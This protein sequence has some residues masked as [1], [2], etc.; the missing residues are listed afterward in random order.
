M[1]KMRL[2][3]FLILLLTECFPF[4]GY[5]EKQDSAQ[6]A[7]KVAG[8]LDIY[9]GQDF[10]FEERKRPYTTQAFYDDEPAINLAFVDTTLTTENYRG[11]IS[12]QAGSSVESNYAAEAAEGWRYVQEAYGGVKLGKGLWLDAGVFFSHIGMEGWI[13]RDNINYTRSLVA[14]YSPYYQTGLRLNCEINDRWSAQILGLRGW[15]NISEER[16]P[17][18]GTQLQ[19]KASDRLTIL[20]SL[21]VGNE[22]GQ[23]VFNDLIAKFVLS[24]YTQLAAQFDLGFQKMVGANVGAWWH[25]WSIVGQY[26]LR[27]DLAIGA[28]VERFLDPHQA[29]IT[30]ISSDRFGVFGASFNVDYEIVSKLIWRT[31]FRRGQDSKAVFSDGGA[32]FQKFS[33]LLVTSLSFSLA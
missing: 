3:M 5:A 2:T 7:L 15:Q 22:K 8:F 27:P 9:Y 25:G 16:D 20:H 32:D 12:A 30:S 18:L 23:R 21:F 6:S 13:S 4:F 19:Y 24:E 33:N 1:R 28:R 31:E 26:R 14:E 10:N 17:A 11:R 29:V